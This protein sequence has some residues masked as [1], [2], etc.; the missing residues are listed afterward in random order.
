MSV[1][2]S[3]I[4][5]REHGP[6]DLVGLYDAVYTIITNRGCRYN[7]RAENV[8][9]VYGASPGAWTT[10]LTAPRRRITCLSFSDLV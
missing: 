9:I 6:E 8:M 3:S 4:M 10:E 2:M 1:G 7:T 5:S